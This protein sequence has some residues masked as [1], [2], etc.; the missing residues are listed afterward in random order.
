MKGMFTDRNHQ[1][2]EAEIKS[3]LGSLYS[4]WDRLIQF[5]ETHDHV[6]GFWTM[7]G[8]KQMGWNLRY[9][10]KGKALVALY[11]QQDGIIANV[12]LGAKQARLALNLELGA[13][14]SELL[15]A[16]PQLHDGRW[17]FIPVVTAADVEDVKQLLWVKTGS[18]D[19]NKT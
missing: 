12:V 10:W 14:V 5:I 19:V 4:L 2:T 6:E 11:P 3:G 18:D 17:L 8:P 7:W 13:E 1:P 16:A 15:R 9:R